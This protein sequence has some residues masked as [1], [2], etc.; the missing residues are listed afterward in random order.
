MSVAASE[1]ESVEKLLSPEVFVKIDAYWRACNCNPHVRERFIYSYRL[2][3]DLK[4]N[5][6]HILGVIHGKRLLES[7]ERFD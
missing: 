3:Y 6:I 2:I 5:G 7:V 4:D 1:M